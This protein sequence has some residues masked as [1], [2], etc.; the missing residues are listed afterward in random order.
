MCD[1]S[2]LFLEKGGG[3]EVVFV[4]FVAGGGLFFGQSLFDGDYGDCEYKGYN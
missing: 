3:K 1:V 2:M 4:L